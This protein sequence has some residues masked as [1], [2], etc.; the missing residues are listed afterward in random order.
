MRVKTTLKMFSITENAT[1]EAVPE[2]IEPPYAAQ[3]A[4]TQQQD[5]W[6]TTVLTLPHLLAQEARMTEAA[7][8]QPLTPP[9]PRFFS[10]NTA[11]LLH[12]KE[13]LTAQ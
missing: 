5:V 9:A 10:P 7:M 2:V 1:W 13:E 4:Q 11:C 12:Q 6:A 8:G 3:H